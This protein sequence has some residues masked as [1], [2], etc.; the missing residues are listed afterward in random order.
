MT[1]FRWQE[2]TE[3]GPLW[4]LHIFLLA[5]HNEDF[6]PSKPELARLSRNGMGMF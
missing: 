4:K 1:A 3:A 6:V 5:K 2:R